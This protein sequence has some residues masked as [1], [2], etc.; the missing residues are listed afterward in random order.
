MVE[1]RITRSSPLRSTLADLP[2]L[3]GCITPPRPAPPLAYITS[4]PPPEPTGNTISVNGFIRSVRKQK[5]H[6][7]ASIGDG[8]TL[9]PLQALLSPEQAEGLSTG[10][11]VNI[12]GRHVA[13]PPGK[14][15]ASELHALAVEI[16]GDNDATNYPIQ[17]KYQTT[18]FLRTLPHLRTRLP[19]NSLLLRLRSQ[20]IAQLTTFFASR[21]FV[22]THPPIITSNDCEGAGEVFTVTSSAGQAAPSDPDGEEAQQHFFRNPK[23]LTVSSQLHL[24]AL[25]QSVG[26]VWTLSPTFRAD[27]S[28]TPRHL[29]EFYMLEAELAF[30]SDVDSLMDVVEDMLKDLARGLVSSRTG[31]ELLQARS[32][33]WIQN[34]ELGVLSAAD[35]Q[36]RWDGLLASEW[37]RMKYTIAIAKLKEAVEIDGASFDVAPIFSSGLH[38]QHEHYLAKTFGNGGPVF[39]TDYPQELKAFYMPPSAEQEAVADGP[40]VACFDLLVPD[41][42]ELVGGSVRE[43]RTSELLKA[44]EKHEQLNDVVRDGKGKDAVEDASLQW[45]VDLRRYGS[46]PH[47]GFGLGFDRLLLYLSGVTNIREVVTFPRWPGRCDC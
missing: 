35:L 13:C 3:P 36:A 29:S 10:I 22:Q 14:E 44:M 7:F 42:C 19:F 23:Y 6:A 26:K 12:Q 30:T 40:T 32:S 37:P 8:S 45:Y 31:K 34:E 21:D 46:V 2:G 20:V 24:E 1:E 5:K 25:A 15:Q 47:G 43:H 28:H 39:V 9:S 27:R 17:K 41:V 11:A 18:E 38:A 4:T 33:D 16:L